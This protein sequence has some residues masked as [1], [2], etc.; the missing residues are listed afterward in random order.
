MPT[1][2]NFEIKKRIMRR[3]YLIYTLRQLTH[4][5][6]IKTFLFFATIFAGSKL[7]SVTDIILNMRGLSDFKGFVNF[8]FSAFFHTDLFV[9]MITITSL[10]IFMAILTDIIRNFS[11][12]LIRLRSR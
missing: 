8:S 3:V 7:V 1:L 6:V 5:V 4:P 9:Q 12:G 2:S 10:L 11:G